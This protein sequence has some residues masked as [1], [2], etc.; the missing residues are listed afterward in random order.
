MQ[1]L[2]QIQNNTLGN[3]SVLQDESLWWASVWL[4]NQGTTTNSD[5][6]VCCRRNLQVQYGTDGVIQKSVT[7]PRLDLNGSVFVDDTYLADNNAY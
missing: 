1:L 3:E 6:I 4:N 5:G 7:I 2:M